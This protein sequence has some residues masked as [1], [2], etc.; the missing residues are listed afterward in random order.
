MSQLDSIKDVLG[1]H[2]FEIFKLDP[3]KSLEALN[4]VKDA[5]APALGSA[6][7]SIESLDEIGSLLDSANV[8]D[9]LGEALGLLLTGANTERQKFLIDVFRPVTTVG[10][11]Q[12]TDNTF[13]LVFRGDLPLMFA[14]LNLCLRGEWGNVW[15]AL[16]S[17][18]NDAVAQA[19][20]PEKSQ[21]T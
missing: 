7:G 4:V 13:S 8:S 18:I 14:W 10:G 21:T 6:L 16:A 11:K 1:E 15:G 2:E 12:L 17:G 3:L 19:Q 20:Q 5:L 9:G